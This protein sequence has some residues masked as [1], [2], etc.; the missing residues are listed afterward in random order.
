MKNRVSRSWRAGICW[1]GFE[2]LNDDGDIDSSFT[3]L[4][5]GFVS[6]VLSLLIFPL[7]TSA[8]FYSFINY[9][10]ARIFQLNFL[11]LSCCFFNCL[12]TRL[13]PLTASCKDNYRLLALCIK[14]IEIINFSYFVF[15]YTFNFRCVAREVLAHTVC[16]V[17]LFFLVVSTIFGILAYLFMF[18]EV[19]QTDLRHLVLGHPLN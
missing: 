10:W 3:K 2:I 19:S 9:H 5:L 4:H 8:S 6:N 18:E 11:S 17:S 7:S 13:L 14:F 15:V 12:T 1:D 16:L